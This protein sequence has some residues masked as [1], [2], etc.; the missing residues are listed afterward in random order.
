MK[1]IVK[2]M[3][4]S[5]ANQLVNRPGFSGDW[6]MRAVLHLRLKGVLLRFVMLRLTNF[7]R[8]K[9]P[10][11]RE[12]SLYTRPSLWLSEFCRTDFLAT[13]EIKTGT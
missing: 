4:G 13:Q 1:I 9:R 11:I 7:F 5:K 2:H 10:Y 8:G 3:T 12:A 6:L